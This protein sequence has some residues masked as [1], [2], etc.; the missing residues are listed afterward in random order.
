MLQVRTLHMHACGAVSCVVSCRG[1]TLGPRSWRASWC[2]AMSEQ[3]SHALEVSSSDMALHPCPEPG[4][5]CSGRNLYY[6]F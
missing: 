4:W 3:G 5:H 1:V 2:R 6:L